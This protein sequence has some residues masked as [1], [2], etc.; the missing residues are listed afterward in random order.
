MG[1]QGLGF[2][3]CAPVSISHGGSWL[4]A[5][6]SRLMFLQMHGGSLRARPRRSLPAAFDDPAAPRCLERCD[7]LLLSAARRSSISVH[8][9][10]S[11]LLLTTEYAPSFAQP[12]F[13]GG[14]PCGCQA[15]ASGAAAGGDSGGCGIGARDTSRWPG[16]GT[17]ARRRRPG[18]GA[19]AAGER[20]RQLRFAA[21]LEIGDGSVSNGAGSDDPGRRPGGKG[22][23]Q[24]PAVEKSSGAGD[25][26]AVA[27]VR[28]GAADR[29]ELPV[30]R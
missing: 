5:M 20:C 23:R 30:R 13:Y 17:V 15:D 6:A 21:A 25:R 1:L 12:H 28:V 29:Y 9:A 19:A 8:A 16:G 4:H 2:K 14:R 24:T 27:L 22:G 3:G 26:A 18:G 11:D 10:C 7:L